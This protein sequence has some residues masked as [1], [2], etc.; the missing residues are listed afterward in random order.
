MD[1]TQIHEG[2]RRMRFADV[3]GRSERSELS[4]MEAAELLGISERTFRRWRDRHRDAGLARISQTRV[5]LDR[6]AARLAV[7]F[8]YPER[9]C[10][11]I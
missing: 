1:R 7:D 9:V 3:L 8:G 4:Q 11:R 5:V 2:I 10:G 6:R